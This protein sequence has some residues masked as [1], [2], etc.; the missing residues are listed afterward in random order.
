M[1][2]L[3]HKRV[4]LERPQPS[5]RRKLG[6]LEKHKDYVKRAKDFHRKNETVKKLQRKA[7]FR[8]PDEFAYG[9]ISH[10]MNE[11]GKTVKKK[12]HLTDDQLRLADDQDAQYV[13]M[14]EQMDRLGAKKRAEAL[15]FLDVDRPNKHTLFVDDDDI[16][17]TG[18]ASS[19]SAPASKKKGVK[20]IKAVK[21]NGRQLK[22]FD[23]AA[24]LDTHQS[25]L[26][27]KANRPR[28][29]QLDTHDFSDK[30]ELEAEKAEAYKELLQRQERAKSLRT[31]R[32]ELEYRS[33]IR[34]KGTKMKVADATEDRPEQYKWLPC[35]KK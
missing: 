21:K 1:R 5:T 19:S 3:V 25:L 29:R 7:Y 32:E 4:H 23:V 20:S 14:R 35:R 16:A 10:E 34:Q 6:Y 22:N 15:H 13:G 17:G 30:K 24:H 12:T 2:G 8:N 33:N 11:K 31:V 28:M 27:C 26:G 9:M 18:A